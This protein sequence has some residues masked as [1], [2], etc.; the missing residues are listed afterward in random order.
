MTKIRTHN[1]T[2]LKI[3]GVAK[4][5]F[6]NFRK[7][8]KLRK[9]IPAPSGHNQRQK[10]LPTIKIKKTIIKPGNRKDKNFP[11]LITASNASKPLSL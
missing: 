2:F 10:K 6:Q 5:V 11:E 4:E 3:F 8:I 7:T 9:S 1:P